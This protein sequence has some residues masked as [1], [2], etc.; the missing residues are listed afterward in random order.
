MKSNLNLK[1]A[2]AGVLC[3]SAYFFYKQKSSIS[4]D[5]VGDYFSGATNSMTQGA[6][7]LVDYVTGE[8]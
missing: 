5:A 4:L 7:E 2:A 3:A 1:I 8:H 6:A